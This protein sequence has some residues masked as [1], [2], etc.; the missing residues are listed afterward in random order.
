MA[1]V[2]V[3]EAAPSEYEAVGRLTVEAYAQYE[4]VIGPEFWAAYQVDL[5][6]AAGRA[7]DAEILVAETS[8]TIVG[9]VALYPTDAPGY[10]RWPERWASVRVLAV[11][12]LHRRTGVARALMDEC[13]RRARAWGAVALGLHTV[14]FMTGAVQLYG[15]MGLDRLPQHDFQ[16]TESG[17]RIL[18][19]GL[20]LVPG[21]LGSA[22]GAPVRPDA[23]RRS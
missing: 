20:E 9:A 15:G 6:D 14:R 8:G 5:R 19:F 11:S 3:R 13:I 12:P 2:T 4:A 17:V 21:G 18:A 7:R 16:G 22:T 10:Y 23:G 1:A